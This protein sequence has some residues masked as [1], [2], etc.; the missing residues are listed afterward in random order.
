VHDVVRV[1]PPSQ[2]SIDSSPT[3]DIAE[4]ASHS[5]VGVD[6]TSSPALD[7]CV[8]A[9]DGGEPSPPL[10]HEPSPSPAPSPSYTEH[11]HA[12]STI[13]AIETRTSDTAKLDDRSDM[14]PL[15]LVPRPHAEGQQPSLGSGQHACASG[16]Q[17]QPSPH[18]EPDSDGQPIVTMQHVV[19]VSHCAGSSSSPEGQSIALLHA[20]LADTQVPSPHMKPHPPLLLTVPCGVIMKFIPPAPPLPQAH[21]ER[22]A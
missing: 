18:S 17:Q 16:Q 4:A 6:V 7:T 3:H 12:I 1:T 8:G 5:G 2:N 9:V 13:V 19:G 21:V 11:E 20:L 22:G 15:P 10:S 14:H